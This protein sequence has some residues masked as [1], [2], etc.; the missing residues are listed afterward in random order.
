MK[1]SASRLRELK[2]KGDDVTAEEAA[3]LKQLKKL[4]KKRLSAKS[5]GK[6]ICEKANGTLI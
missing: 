2:D 5:T 6:F 1:F 3:E 4:K